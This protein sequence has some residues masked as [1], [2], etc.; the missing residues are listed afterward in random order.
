MLFFGLGIHLDELGEVATVAKRGGDRR[1]V[2]LES[3]GGD[4]ELLAG[5]CGA[6]PFDE[7]V[8]SGLGATAQS[9][10]QDQLGASCLFLQRTLGTLPVDGGAGSCH[11]GIIP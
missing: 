9:K 6:K 4:L 2:R 7:G 1:D 3:V 11:A 10:I 8:R 5:S